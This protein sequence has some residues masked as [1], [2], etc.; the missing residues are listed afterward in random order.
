MSHKSPEKLKRQTQP[1]RTRWLI[2]GLGALLALIGVYIAA[3]WTPQGQTFEDAALHGARLLPAVD[4]ES[5]SD[6]LRVIS[7]S[8][9]GVATVVVAIVG[10][11]RG[12]FKLAVAGAGTIVCSVLTTE[13]LKKVILPRPILV[14]TADDIA[15]NSFPSGH[16]TIAMS[17]LIAALLVSSYRWRGWVMLFVMTWSTAIGAATIAAHWH[18][19][20]DTIG[21]NCVALIWGAIF[22]SWLASNAMVKPYR[23]HKV[24]LRVVYVVL[25]TIT[26]ASALG[27]GATL[28]VL[29]W[30]RVSH[31]SR[32]FY[33]NSYEAVHALAFAGALLAALLFWWS[34]RRLEV[35]YDHHVS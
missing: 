23:G 14:P 17:I 24:R 25:A 32:D 33:I 30:Q 34:W 10:F 3:V 13:L 12:G 22:S 20:S 7:V 31:T 35:V 21:A 28:G 15:H 19:L 29:N 2:L 26:A 6:K 27:V 9:L 16:T 8:S 11:V 1:A 18:R 4:M 5:A